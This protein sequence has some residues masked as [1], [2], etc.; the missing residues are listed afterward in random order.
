MIRSSLS[1][2]FPGC[3]TYDGSN[4]YFPYKI[5]TADNSELEVNACT[6]A[7]GDKAPWCKIRGGG[8]GYCDMSQESGCQIHHMGKE[9]KHSNTILCHY[10]F[11]KNTEKHEKLE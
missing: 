6:M 2:H 1:L 7:E 11:L 10:H 4:C 5:A 3:Q 8:W 9:P